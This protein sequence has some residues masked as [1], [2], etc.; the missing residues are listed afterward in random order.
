MLLCRHP[1]FAP[2][3]TRHL[4]QRLMS[5]TP[6]LRSGKPFLNLFLEFWIIFFPCDSALSMDFPQLSQFFAER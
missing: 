1:G 4:N 3:T 2:Y 6:T 5:F